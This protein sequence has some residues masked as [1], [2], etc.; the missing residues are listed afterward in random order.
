MTELITS[1]ILDNKPFIFVKFGDGEYE[2]IINK[3]GGN[4]DR[5]PYTE[6]KK[7]GLIESI[8]YYSNLNNVYIGRWGHNS[9]IP[10]YF[11][12]ITER[13]LSWVDY[14]TC[15]IDGSLCNSI[16]KLN[17]YKSVQE[18]PRR[19][20]IIGHR[21]LVKAKYLFNLDTHVIVPFHG[22]FENE[23]ERVFNEVL[24]SCEGIDNPL[25]IT[26]AGMASKILIRE[27][28]KKM[29]NGMYIDFGSALDALCTKRCSRNQNI[30]YETIVNYFKSI[31]PDNWDDS[32][33]DYIYEEA[34]QNLGV[35]YK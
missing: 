22:W 2:C 35:H 14:H 4:C 15:I 34:K 17:L 6:Q 7:E 31:L 27:L 12:T 3:P 16:Y 21:L 8:T 25:I 9:K 26:C 1:F 18:C 11:N 10:A 33:F 29:P 20:I 19:K 24:K 13:P 5:D 30:K 28:H 32:E 23:Y